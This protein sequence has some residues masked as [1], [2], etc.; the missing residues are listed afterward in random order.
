MFK[1]FWITPGN[2][3]ERHLNA[4]FYY[5]AMHSTQSDIEFT[6]AKNK[7]EWEQSTRMNAF[8]KARNVSYKSS[9]TKVSHCCC[10]SYGSMCFDRAISYMVSIEIQ[11]IICFRLKIYVLTSSF[12]KF[13]K[14]VWSEMDPSIL[15]PLKT[16][17]RNDN[18]SN[19]K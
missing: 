8:I 6:K 18:A 1:W 9:Y 7:T 15:I 13:W 5:I 17:N 4:Y 11:N 19:F 2:N 14:C 12:I 10:L 16:N 3:D